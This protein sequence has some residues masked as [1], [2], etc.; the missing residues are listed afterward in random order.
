[1]SN[2]ER[3]IGNL[4]KGVEALEASVAEIRADVKTL[5]ARH[6]QSRGVIYA[7]SAV[8]GGVTGLFSNLIK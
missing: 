1:M 2:N 8:V 7:I 6:N 3:I 5:L 4:Q